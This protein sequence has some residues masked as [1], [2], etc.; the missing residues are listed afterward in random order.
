MVFTR[1]GVC[2]PPPQA[3]TPGTWTAVECMGLDRRAP[4]GSL[5]PTGG[6]MGSGYVAPSQALMPTVVKWLL[7]F[8][9]YEQTLWLGKAVPR[10][11]LEAGS[12]A[13]VV[14]RSPS[15]Y[16]RLS[17]SLHATSTTTVV[18]NVTL[19]PALA[20]AGEHHA[21]AGG[22]AW[23]PGG[24]KVRIRHPSKKLSSVAVGGKS[25]PNFNA[26]E[27]TVVF[28][29]A[30]GDTTALQHIVATFA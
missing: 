28:A 24:V 19:P 5:R 8:E 18:A 27:E 26:T 2:D 3:Q 29:T 21:A 14:E 12:P 15:S 10:A 23:P 6:G 25:W 13:V 7:Q 22:F 16:G 17:F 30:P 20:A 9:D 1:C 4:S 11:W